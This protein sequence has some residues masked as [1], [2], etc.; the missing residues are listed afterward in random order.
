M[1]FFLVGIIPTEIYIAT[2]G[3][4]SDC[5]RLGIADLAAIVMV[6][7]CEHAPALGQGVCY[8]RPSNLGLQGRLPACF[9]DR[10]TPDGL[11][12]S[13]VVVTVKLFP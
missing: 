6:L 2:L 1:Q 10:P 7:I 4:F 11:T 12:A 5:W 3:R 13:D 9:S 8:N